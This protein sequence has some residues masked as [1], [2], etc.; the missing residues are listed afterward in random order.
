MDGSLAIFHGLHKLANYD[1]QGKLKETKKG[2]ATYVHR[3]SSAMGKVFKD[4]SS[5]P[6]PKQYTVNNSFVTKADKLY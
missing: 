2:K 1:V 6:R 4:Y 3:L 5:V